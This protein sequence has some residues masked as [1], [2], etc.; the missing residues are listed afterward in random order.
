[1]NND[2]REHAEANPDPWVGRAFWML[3]NSAGEW[4]ADCDS[5]FVTRDCREA[6][7]FPN[8]QTAD[9]LR[10]QLRG[11][12]WRDFKPTEH[13]YVET[14]T[15]EHAE[16]GPRS[17]PGHIYGV[18]T[19]DPDVKAVLDFLLSNDQLKALRQR[20]S[21]HELRVIANGACFALGARRVITALTRAPDS[22]QGQT[23]AWV[24]E[25]LMAELA[26]ENIDVSANVAI[27]HSQHGEFT[28]P[29]YTA[30]PSAP[31]SVAFLDVVFDGPPSHES[32]RFVEVE[33]PEGCSVNAG[34]W[35]DRKDGLWA[36]RIPMPAPSAG[37]PVTP[38]TREEAVEI[39][40][41][42]L[43]ITPDIENAAVQGSKHFWVVRVIELMRLID[44]ARGVK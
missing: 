2:T 24:Q 37:R 44:A 27:G 35:I 42:A 8:E 22:A 5:C 14:P 20:L 38:C 9:D 30:P 19:N 3:E 29:L 10:R 18:S 11:V 28:V 4:L 36:L 39:A 34:E 7:R 43:V 31:E 15:R 17:L 32:G 12:K 13:A 25:S 23:V 6:L 33:N 16:G 41:R 1:M 21:I 40:K 26:D